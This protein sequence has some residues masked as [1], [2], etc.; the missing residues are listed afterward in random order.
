MQNYYEIIGVNINSDL[1]TIKAVY[2]QKIKEYHPD[3]YDG[4][5]LFAEEMTAKL[6]EAYGVLKNDQ[7]RKEYNKTL[8]LNKQKQTCNKPNIFAR[9]KRWFIVI[10]QNI[11][12][13]LNCICDGVKNVFKSKNNLTNEQKDRI[14]L[15]TIIFVQSI[16]IVILIILIIAT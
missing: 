6:N 8:N 5:K 16:L 10:K 13:F 14:K 4:D 9:I 1:A 12:E 15:N 7:L 3:I 11:K 2:L